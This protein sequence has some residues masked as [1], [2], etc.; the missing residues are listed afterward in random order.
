[1]NPSKRFTK[2]PSADLSREKP[3]SWETPE[4][5]TAEAIKELMEKYDEAR[6]AWLARF[7]SDFGFND[8]FTQQVKRR[9]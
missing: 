3:P 7:G 6:A 2:K 4:M 1:M 9:A 5:N 8:W